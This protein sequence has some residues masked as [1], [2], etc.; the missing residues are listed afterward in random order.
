MS[1]LDEALNNLKRSS[2]WCDPKKMEALIDLVL[3]EKS[4]VCLEIGVFSGKS[5]LSMAFGLREKHTRH[6]AQ[7]HG[8][9]YGVDSWSVPDCLID[10]S[11]E[12]AKW[13]SQNVNL[14]DIYA[15]CLQHIV[16]TKLS[17]YIRL[18]RMSSLEAVKIAPMLDL[19]HVDGCHS[20]WSSTSD[21]TLWLPHLRPGGILVLDDVNWPST[22]TCVRFAKKLCDEIGVTTSK[23]SV[24]GVYRKR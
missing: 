23:E 6:P 10:T 7:P 8:I 22:Q 2:G 13:W 11:P 21:I 16:E 24:F 17:R 19:L 18:L 14:E 4:D 9:V 3:K 20:E 1:Y 5:L 12:D 15:E